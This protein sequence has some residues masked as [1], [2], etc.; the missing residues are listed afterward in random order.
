MAKQF[1][2]DKCKKKITGE[3]SNTYITLRTYVKNED[4]NISVPY[5]R[6]KS[7]VM[8]KDLC[9]NCSFEFAKTI[10]DFF[11]TKGGY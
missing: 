9:E 7:N 2:C 6:L 3:R 5:K 8:N 10:V 1:I 11:M 4:K